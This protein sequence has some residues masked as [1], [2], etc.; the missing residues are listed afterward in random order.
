MGRERQAIEII[1]WC[2]P[3]EHERDAKFLEELKLR[4]GHVVEDVRRDFPSYFIDTMGLD[5]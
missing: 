1:V 3:R 5:A 2:E 4:V